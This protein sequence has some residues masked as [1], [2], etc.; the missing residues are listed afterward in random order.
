MDIVSQADETDELD[1][2]IVKLGGFH[3][4]MSY[5]G[6]VVKI[7]GGSGLEEMWCEAA[8]GLLILEYCEG[9]GFLSG[10]DVETLGGIL[11]EVLHLSS[12]EESFLSKVK[13][14]LSVVSSAVK[15]LEERS[16]TAKLWLQYFKE[17]SVMYDFV[18]EERTGNWNLNLYFVQRLLVPLHAVGH[19]H[20]DKSAHLF[21]HNMSKLK[22]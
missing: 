16:R 6:A 4:L 12:S 2:I 22:D 5:M 9:N 17:V 1:I 21:L 10:F 15:T 13:P 3:L 19:I 11:N 8:I 18:R 14:L 7:M 20:F